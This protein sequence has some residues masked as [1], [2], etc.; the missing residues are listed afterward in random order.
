MRSTKSF[1]LNS[2]HNRDTEGILAAQADVEAVVTIH[3][4][5]V[6]EDAVEAKD[7]LVDV[8]IDVLRVYDT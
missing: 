5:G 1:P 8:E 4:D 6:E 7:E 3:V 2:Q